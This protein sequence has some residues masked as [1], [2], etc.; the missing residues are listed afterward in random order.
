MVRVA[1]LSIAVAACGPVKPAVAPP[2]TNPPDR[3]SATAM[4]DAGVDAAVTVPS[5]PFS[6]IPPAKRTWERPG[7]DHA[8]ACCKSSSECGGL[9]C[10]PY[11]YGG[12][13]CRDVCTIHCEQGDFCPGM[14]G[15]IHAEPIACP[16]DG[17]CPVGPPNA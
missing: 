16:A 6:A 7:G 12:G 9:A 8:G 10:D 4:H 1:L 11:N 15:V 14:G 2:P 13:D 17:R 5:D 3:G